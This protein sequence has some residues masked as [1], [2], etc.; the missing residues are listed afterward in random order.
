M[1]PSNLKYRF[2]K[3]GTIAVSC[4]GSHHLAWY[5]ERT[6]DD[7]QGC[8]NHFCRDCPILDCE[9]SGKSENRGLEAFL[10][11]RR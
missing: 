8:L 6:K 7:I 4:K 1:N 5:K 11:S 2:S 3:N 10:E 9:R